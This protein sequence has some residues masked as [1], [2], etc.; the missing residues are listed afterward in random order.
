MGKHATQADELISDA[1]LILSRL[2]EQLAD[3]EGEVDGE[4]VDDA[5]DDLPG[6]IGDLGA[7]VEV[8]ENASELLESIDL[9]SL[10]EAIDPDDLVEAIDAGSIPDAIEDRDPT[11]AIDLKALFATVKLRELWDSADFRE[12]MERSSA[13]SNAVSEV[14]NGDNED[15][16]DDGG[17]VE[18]VT[19]GEDGEGL[20]GDDEGQTDG[21]EGLMETASEAMDDATDGLSESMAPDVGG[22]DESG[23]VDLPSEEYQVM[24]QSKAMDAVE[25]FR[26]GVIDARSTLKEVYEENRERSK[27]SRAERQPSSRNPTAYSSIPAERV[28]LGSVPNYSTMPDRAPLHSTAPSGSRRLYGDRFEQEADDE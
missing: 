18:S 1:Q 14:T 5:I 2:E 21:D 27:Q 6:A 9:E 13:L 7:L 17:L 26:E 19:G 8:A 12:V 28:D 24:I 16:E 25:E 23:L 15:D 3:A 11:E 10:P 4:S 20:L 22:D